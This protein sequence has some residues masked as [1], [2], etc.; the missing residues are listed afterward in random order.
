M[1]LA[2]LGVGGGGSVVSSGASAA[3]ASAV[4]DSL[5]VVAVEPGYIVDATPT[6]VLYI[7]QGASPELRIHDLGSN[8]TT[9]VPVPTGRHAVQDGSLIDGGALFASELTDVTT[10]E[11][12][13]WKNGQ[14][15]SLGPVNSEGSI[16]ANG[17]FA[18]WSN[19]TTL[20]R[21]DLAAAQTVTVSTTAGNIDNDV[22]AQGDVVYWDDTYSVRRWHNGSSAQ[23]SQQPASTWATYPLIDGSNVVYRETNPCCGLQH[24]SVAFSDGQSETVLDS[25]REELWPSPVRD[26]L[27]TNGWIAFTRPQSTPKSPV[28]VWTRDP[29]G[30][31]AAVTSNPSASSNWMLGLN[32]TGQVI[33]D[34]DK[35]YLGAAGEVPF[36]L[37]DRFDRAFWAD[38][39]WYVI[40]G[41][42][43]DTT[44]FL[45]VETDTAIVFRPADPTQATDAGFEFNST[46][47][48][49]DFECRLDGGSWEACSS[50]ESYSNLSEGAHT[51]S[52]AATDPVANEADPTPASATWVVDHTAPAPFDLVSPPADAWTNARPTFQWQNSSDSGPGPIHYEVWIDGVEAAS[53]SGATYF[54]PGGL[55]HGP[56]SWLVKAID[57]AGNTRTSA[58]SSFTVDGAAPAAFTNV[59]PADNSAVIDPTPTL[60]WTASSD[61]ESGLAGYRVYI[62]DQLKGSVLSGET[63]FTPAGP[64]TD[65]THSW[66]VEAF[67]EVGYTRYG[68]IWHVLVATRPPQAAV[69]SSGPDALAGT[70]VGFDASASRDPNALG[71]VNYEWDPEGTG[72]FATSTGATPFFEH[73]YGRAGTYDA[74]VRVT[75]IFGFTGTATVRIVVHTPPPAGA[76]GVSINGADRFT[77]DPHV[78]LKVVWPKYVDTVLLSND[79]GFAPARRVPVDAS[80]PWTLHSAG[81]ERLPRIVYVRFGDSSQ[82]FTDDIVLDSVSPVISAAKVTH[83]ARRA[84]RVSLAASDRNSGL[85]GM[86]ITA[87]RA[88]PGRILP[89]ARHR[90]YDGKRPRW[91]RVRDRAGNLSAWRTIVTVPVR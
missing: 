17:D 15:T 88:K 24:G 39:H 61:S 33:Y 54:P 3:T 34:A 81:S 2:A 55:S 18:I 27:A 31:I 5:S 26:Y 10:A 13:E 89:F 80:I 64:L 36:T 67:D 75:N 22:S 51:F 50:P 23:V 21:R 87:K 84:Y 41:V 49:A 74:A 91:A 20:F 52:V 7:T 77:N 60:T 53:V 25:Y 69:T 16:V 70:P 43:N 30:N 78:T 83:V 28:E 44:T 37:P 8:V 76:L 65:G 29:Q 79:G 46:S 56:H 9:V 14:L 72:T 82:T 86:Q 11:L 45:R 12:D 85:A 59:A 38:H 63:S 73:T 32:P 6:R 4:S 40:G 66:R 42:V 47:Q 57:R 71:L 1:L 58:T 19:G 35:T 90:I 68:P 48:N 62:D